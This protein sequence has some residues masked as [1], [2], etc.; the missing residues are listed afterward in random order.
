MEYW[1]IALAEEKTYSDHGL[2]SAF[3]NPS[4]SMARRLWSR[5]FSSI[6]KNDRAPSFDSMWF[7]TSNNSLPVL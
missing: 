4:S 2:F 5:K 7:I 6:M 1:P 3:M